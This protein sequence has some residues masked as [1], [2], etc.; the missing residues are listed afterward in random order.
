MTPRG[1]FSVVEDR[2]DTRYVWVRSRTRA[3]IDSLVAAYFPR[4]KVRIKDGGDYAWRIRVT[5]EQWA[6]ALAGLAMEI[7]YLN[8][9]DEVRRRQGKR[10]A[11]LYSRVWSILSVL[12]DRPL[13]SRRR[14]E[15]LDPRYDYD[16][17]FDRHF[18]DDDTLFDRRRRPPIIERHAR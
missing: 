6:A 1:F 11:E 3:D 5:K 16:G 2:A 17:Y 4:R 10:R 8:F 12:N 7:D 18:P 15:P 9:K 14:R 13:F